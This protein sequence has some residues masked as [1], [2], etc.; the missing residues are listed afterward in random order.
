MLVTCPECSTRYQVDPGALGGGRKV[1][2]ARC[3]HSWVQQPETDAPDVDGEAGARGDIAADDVPDDVPEGIPDAIPDEI[4]DGG[5]A[6]PVSP[7]VEDEPP[8]PE[9]VPPP[10]TAEPLPSRVR[11][12]PKARPR[13]QREPGRRLATVLWIL[14]FLVVAGVVGSAVGMRDMVMATWPASEA[15]YDLVGLGPEPPGAGLGLLGV[16]WHAAN[17]DGASVLRI[18][19]E[20]TNRTDRVRDV[21]RLLGIIYDADE[22][23]LHRWSFAAPEGR[24][25]PGET[26]SFETEL[27]NPATGASRL[28]IAFDPHR[29]R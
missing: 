7:P 6:A 18:K 8:P 20:I 13:R 21:P 14:F 12:A 27:R 19:G 2:C 25:L 5:N 15:V 16:R 17:Q 24:L 9:M 10:L 23:E 4:G 26:V 22:R 11:E 3:G 29:R 28:Q 1:R